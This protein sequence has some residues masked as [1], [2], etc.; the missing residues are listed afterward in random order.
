MP[1]KRSP[2]GLRDSGKVSTAARPV[3]TP[4]YGPAAAASPR[5]FLRYHALP[6]L[7]LI[8]GLFFTAAAFLSVRKQERLKVREAFMSE[9]S[10]DMA[11]VSQGFD[12]SILLV[13]SI[14]AYF[15]ATDH[16][17]R[18][19]FHAFVQPLLTQYPGV[20]ALEWIPRVTLETRSEFEKAGQRAFPGFQ[21][22]EREQ[23]GVMV[24][25]ASRPEYFP[26]YFADPYKNNE[27]ALG[28][29]L[30][31]DS[32]RLEALVRARDTG[33][34]VATP[35]IVLVQEKT[36]QFG[37]LVFAP[38][39]RNGMSA[40]TPEERRAN[41]LGFIVGVFRIGDVVETALR[42]KPTALDLTLYDESAGESQRFLYMYLAHTRAKLAQQE[43]DQPIPNAG[44]AYTT[45]RKIGDRTWLIRVSPAPRQ[46]KTSTSPE[47]W[48]I[49]LTGLAITLV[50]AAYAQTLRKHSETLITANEALATSENELADAN[51]Q[52]KSEIAE[53]RKT[54]SELRKAKEAA[55]DAS[56]A[57]SEFLANMSHEIRTP[58]NGIIGM[59]E[60]ALD[61]DLSPE[62][63]ED[64][65]IVKASADSLLSVINGILDFSR[66]EAGKLDLDELEF[67]L[68]DS[69]G[70]TINTM[71]LRAH[72]KGLELTCRIAP[73][74]P[75]SFLGDPHRL[76]QVV[77]NLVGN[78]IKFTERG[79]IAVQV[80]SESQKE[81][82]ARLHF[83]V[84]DTGVGIPPE[85][86]R[87]IFEP[88]TQADGSTTRKYGG[89]GLGLSISSRIVERMGGRI[90][91]DSKLG[92]G[93]TFHFTVHLGLQ[94]APPTSKVPTQPVELANLAALVVDDNA[95][96]R[97]ILEEMLLSWQMRPTAA[98]GGQ[99]ALNAMQQARD[100]GNPFQLVLLD[101]Q[102]PEIDGFELAERIKQNPGLAGAVI[103]ML[104][105]AD[106]PGDAARCRALGI[107]VY[108]IKPVKQSELREAILAVLAAQPKKE[109]RA[110]LITRHLCGDRQRLRILL[111]EYN[112][113]NQTLAVRLLEKRGHTVTVVADGKEVVAALGQQLFD[114]VL[115][116][117]QM[118]EMNGFEAAAEIRRKEATTGEHIPIIAMTAYAMKGDRERCITAG[119]D[120]YISKP[121]QPREL[122]ETLEA[123]TQSA[124]Y[125]T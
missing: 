75:D 22:T 73:N 29:D 24:R 78:A 30:G 45:S 51:Q 34:I 41:L 52:L 55:E 48:L 37:F 101:A 76:G 94:E 11:A 5:I 91:V 74:V 77:V 31:S 40:E 15:K 120:G 16:V 42:D 47:A 109:A 122:L 117:V 2:Q 80:E 87:A 98:D 44:L 83:S 115:M 118:P 3:S 25:A 17:T 114:L 38:L 26:V 62:Q 9:A 50:L 39:Y 69:V 105:S 88:F 107:A 14:E 89:T 54:E 19:G 103:M 106:Q 68:R 81:R 113:V 49:L 21:I 7:I 108:L 86:Q 1:K 66:I 97:R 111:A 72:E 65:S 35:R 64:L 33:E 90:W 82:E 102:M 63:R 67:S 79:E 53:R 124:A 95:T 23:Q 61:T 71:R 32:A 36:G 85:K 43:R 6:V 10:N 112:V 100:A 58:M 12:Q 121:I 56:R 18:D 84:T 8:V 110:P 125:R 92:K 4:L 116:D 59:T 28:F 27:R 96:N 119:M 60:L 99:A 104:T 123:L 46:Y 93:S 57:K 20:Q 70:D 13:R